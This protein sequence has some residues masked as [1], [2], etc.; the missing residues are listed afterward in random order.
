MS[1]EGGA[2]DSDRKLILVEVQYTTY[3]VLTDSIVAKKYKKYSIVATTTLH[4]N[5]YSSNKSFTYFWSFFLDIELII[6]VSGV[7]FSLSFSLALARSQDFPNQFYRQ[8]GC[9]HDILRWAHRV[10][11]DSLWLQKILILRFCSVLICVCMYIF[12]L[13][14]AVCEDV[15]AS[16]AVHRVWQSEWRQQL[17]TAVS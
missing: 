12:L 3:L 4:L 15:P 6:C 2:S 11:S 1:G 16:P 8:P 17:Q 14:Q 7:N 5:V 10:L 13:C 9:L